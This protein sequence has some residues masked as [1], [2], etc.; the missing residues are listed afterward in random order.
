[1]PA[2]FRP[3]TL[4]GLTVP[5]RVWMSPMCTYSAESG[6]RAGTPT[7]C[8]LVHYASRAAGGVGLVMVEATAVRS[9]GRISPWDL[10]LWADAQTPDFKRLAKAIS[11]AGAVPAIQLAHA[12]RK[13]S[14]ERP[15]RGGGPLAVSNGGWPTVG[16]SAIAFPGYPRPTAADRSEM[17]NLVASF[18]S[19]ARRA[20]EA[21][22]EVVEVNA[23]HGY[24]LQSFLS[25]I[26][27]RR[28]DEFG[29]SLVNRARFVLEVLDAVRAIWPQHMPVFLRIST[30]DWIA[31]DPADSRE[32]WTVA[33]SIQLALWAREHGVDL[34]DGSSGGVEPK[35]IPSARDYQTA[36][37]ARIRSEASVAIAAVGRI[38]EATWADE[39]V[40]TGQA[41]AVFIGRAL[42]RDASWPNNAAAQLG[43]PPRFVE[44]YAYAL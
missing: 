1:M 9:D 7:D 17:A 3:I 42:L 19:A 11:A 8:H 10:G 30:T 28:T 39:L 35:P 41:D 23:A 43:V 21:G 2:L 26:S 4:R 14:L 36:L 38:T 40:R 27:N 32:G 44:Q 16:P 13:G 18:A 24:L 6:E 33:D 25:P 34:L 15:W 31:E 29:G 5:N 22:F 37:A 12:G 20:L